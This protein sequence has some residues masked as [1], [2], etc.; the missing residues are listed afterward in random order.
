[1]KN[2]T[3]TFIVYVSVLGQIVVALSRLNEGGGNTAKHDHSLATA[4]VQSLLEQVQ[5]WQASSLEMCNES[6]VTLTFAQSLDGKIAVYLDGNESKTS[7]NYP[8]SGQEALLL[9]HALRS[10]HDG[11]LVGGQ[12]LSTDNPR[13]TNRLWAHHATR[14]P[15]PIVLDTEL[16]H[17][18]KALE[19]GVIKAANLIVCC[20]H[21]AASLSESIDEMDPSITILPCELGSNGHLDLRSVLE[22]LRQEFQIRSI[23]VEGGSAVISAFT[24][25][26]LVDCICITVAPRVLGSKGLPAFRFQADNA[27]EFGGIMSFSLGKDCIIMVHKKVLVVDDD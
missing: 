12:T 25:A 14:H 26:N 20:S 23:M 9:T 3:C 1:M 6:F 17:I 11:I 10:I 13:L 22:R 8:I 5:K 21:R 15:R 27:I 2:A 7:S 19:Q 4:T 24:R 16:R 18:R